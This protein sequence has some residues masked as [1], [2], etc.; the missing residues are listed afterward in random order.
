MYT[1][2]LGMTVID[3]W[4]GIKSMNRYLTSVSNFVDFLA[5][6][7]LDQAS[8]S[9]A[10]SIGLPNKITSE[11]NSQTLVSPLTPCIGNK[12][13]SKVILQRGKN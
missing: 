7:M 12:E 5:Q 1:T 6:E 13:H 8:Q 3:T 10:E 2:L 11:N 4:N 9:Q